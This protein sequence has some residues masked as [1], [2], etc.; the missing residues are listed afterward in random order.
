MN[1][2][3]FGGR[4]RFVAAAFL[5]AMAISHVTMLLTVLPLLRGGYQDFTIF[6]TAGR[7]LRSGQ[8]STLY[9]PDAQYRTEKEFA[10]DV[11]IRQAALP[12]IH[13]PFE[14]L[15]FVPFTFLGYVPA[16]A[17][18][19]VLNVALI[20]VN[21]S[22]LRKH[23]G[24]IRTLSPVLLMLA[25][26]GFFPIAIG[27][28]QGQDTILVL[29]SVVFSMVLLQ[30]GR[31]S[32][33]GAALGLGLFK[34]HFIG[35]LALILAM[36]RPRLLAGFVPIALGL[37]CLS[38]AIV[39]WRGVFHYVHYVL[40][41]ERTGAGGAIMASDMPNLRGLIDTLAGLR[42]DTAWSIAITLVCSIAVFWATQWRVRRGDESVLRQ[43]ALATIAA[44][45]ISYHA[46]PYDL[47]LLF[48]SLLVLLAQAISEN[49]RLSRADTALLLLFFLTPLYVLLWLRLN[50]FAWFGLLLIWLLWRLGRPSPTAESILRE[51]T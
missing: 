2:A 49:T 42:T 31:D 25:A 5:F 37:G 16:Y 26:A 29:L 3:R 43:F 11:R 14:A 1:W 8:A 23:F 19:T 51:A 35:P 9:D 10:P 38:I 12:Y 28:I 32:L 17:L 30:N 40:N 50:Q 46:L 48:P 20:I 18:W 24:E 13:T 34:F 21:L 39:G 6:Y 47:V 44:I 41:L 36:R 45:L 15:L 22:L 7:M 27:L 33:A 4:K